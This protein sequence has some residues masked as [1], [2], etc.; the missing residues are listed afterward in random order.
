M[1]HP[2][3]RQLAFAGLIAAFLVAIYA[4]NR[5][6]MRLFFP[7][8][9][10]RVVAIRPTPVPSTPR[11][12]IWVQEDSSIADIVTTA[13]DLPDNAASGTMVLFIRGR[14]SMRTSPPLSPGMQGYEV[15][16]D[17]AARLDQLVDGPPLYLLTCLEHVPLI[18]YLRRTSGTMELQ[19]IYATGCSSPPTCSTPEETE[20]AGRLWTLEQYFESALASSE[21]RPV[22]TLGPGQ[23]PPPTQ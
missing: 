7:P 11:N 2:S 17:Q 18:G 4:L 19:E 6:A 9:V 12:P 22:W 16:S 5:L 21:S 20:A 13:A 10:M 15:A 1:E 14:G 23:S 3:P 8:P